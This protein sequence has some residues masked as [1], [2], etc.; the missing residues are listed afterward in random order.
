[1]SGGGCSQERA[2]TNE[3]A[4]S[5]GRMTKNSFGCLAGVIAARW[6]IGVRAA[7]SGESGSSE[8]RLEE[9][10]RGGSLG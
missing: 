10:R 4:H 1:M 9:G 2:L 8:H 6:I 5:G 3:G 7:P